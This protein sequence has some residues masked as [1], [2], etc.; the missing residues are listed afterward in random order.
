M[1]NKANGSIS[2]VKGKIKKTDLLS[3]QQ[4][5]KNPSTS[6]PLTL[7]I[8]N[9][10]QVAGNLDSTE[11]K[12]RKSYLANFGGMH[13]LTAVEKMNM[14]RSGISKQDLDKLKKDASLDY[15]SLA[16]ALSVTRATL[17][18]KKGREKFNTKVS[19]AIISLTDI[20]SYGYEVFDDKEKFNAWMLRSNKALGGKA[21]NEF[22]D[23]QFGRQEV[24]NVIGRI[25]YGVYS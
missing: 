5:I 7:E 17:I 18:N 2:K 25:E 9:F 20:Y 4:T 24:I 23:N 13:L 14:V 10:N 16:K 6:A 1:V 21:P 8:N 15:D 22:L 12:E 11:N 19:E 3:M